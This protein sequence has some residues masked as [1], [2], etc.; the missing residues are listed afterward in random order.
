MTHYRHPAWTEESR[1]RGTLD[2]VI[3]IPLVFVTFAANKILRFI[4]S[5]LMR[6]LDYAFPLAMQIVWLPLFA[7]KV[8]IQRRLTP[9]QQK[10]GGHGG[11]LGRIC[12]SECR[13]H[14]GL[15]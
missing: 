7:A 12:P 15:K 11:K 9:G 8:P 4:L 10:P 13:K 1:F 5:I 14:G 6:L 3:I 2:D